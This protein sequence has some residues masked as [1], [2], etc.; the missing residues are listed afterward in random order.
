[1]WVSLEPVLRDCDDDG[2]R[3]LLGTVVSALD[4][5]R[6]EACVDAGGGWMTLSSVGE[7]SA[8]S[9]LVRSMPGHCGPIMCLVIGCMDGS[10]RQCQ[11]RDRGQQ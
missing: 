6:R 2:P 4:V 7:L 9:A 1:L 10:G 11:W 5:C 3:R 8:A